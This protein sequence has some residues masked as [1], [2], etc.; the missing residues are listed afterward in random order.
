MTA[1][2]PNTLRP[3][4]FA[5]LAGTCAAGGCRMLSTAHT[6]DNERVDTARSGSTYMP[7]HEGIEPAARPTRSALSDVSVRTTGGLSANT[8]ARVEPRDR[9][10]WIVSFEPEWLEDAD[11]AAS[12]KAESTP[13][14]ARAGFRNPD[15]SAAMYGE[16]IGTDV[17][18]EAEYDDQNVSTENVRR[19]T[20]THTGS[21]FDPYVSNDGTQVVFAST[22]HRETA[23]IYIKDLFGRT[24]TRLTSSPAQDVMPALSP[25]GGYIAFASDRSGSWDLYMMPAT[26]GQ[27]VRLTDD[28]T[29]DLHP[30]WSP[31]GSQ[32]AFSRLGQSSG[33]WELWV[34]DIGNPASLRFIGYGLFPEWSPVPGGGT[35]NADRILFQRSRERGERSFSVWTL[36]YNPTTGN[37]GRETEIISSSNHALINPSWSP[38]GRFIAYAS[39]PPAG[40]TQGITGDAS[41]IWVIGADGR[42]H[43][44]VVGGSTTD[45]MPCWSTNNDLIFVSD[46]GGI[47][48]LWTIELDGPMRTAMAQR[49]EP[50]DRNSRP[51]VGV[52]TDGEPIPGRE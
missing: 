36:D 18:T 23:D 31:D 6:T 2:R 8:A 22:Q 30:S 5:L 15:L 26:G 20:F 27:P 4:A 33:R 47:D 40:G 42:G 46:R 1:D 43:V 12:T 34:L 37:A 48:S 10:G 44:Q 29:H 32:I 21:D 7:E 49:G 17:P 28:A 9:D 39:V 52:P 41:A 38:D 45:L 3:L 11:D 50:I 51:V 16:L 24:V 19:V 35:D 13:A 25:D 14:T